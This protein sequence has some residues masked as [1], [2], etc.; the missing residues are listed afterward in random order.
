MRGERTRV[1]YSTVTNICFRHLN[2]YANYARSLA[3]KR[4]LRSGMSRVSLSL[5]TRERR[6]IVLTSEFL[7][8]NKNT[9][10]LCL[11]LSL[12]RFVLRL[13]KDRLTFNAR[14]ILVSC[15]P[16][17]ATMNW[18]QNSSRISNDLKAK[19]QKMEKKKKRKYPRSL[20]A[21]KLDYT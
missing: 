17:V 7:I 18:N 11:S 9:T 10:S 21:S 20:S 15:A 1:D 4:P 2:N 16:Y 5:T 3:Q 12:A 14:I 13:A 6:P 19:K 8:L